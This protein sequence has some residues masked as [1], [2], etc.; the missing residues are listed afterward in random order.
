LEKA[1]KACEE[2][3][4]YPEM[5]FILRRM[6]NNKQGLKLLIDKIG[7]VKQ[8]IDYIESVNDDE[9]W[10]DLIDYRFCFIL[11]YFILYVFFILILF[12]HFSFFVLV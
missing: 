9:L 4:L 12:I 1:Y 11:F 3:Q 5:V 7:D 6:G 8:A 2:R 10:E